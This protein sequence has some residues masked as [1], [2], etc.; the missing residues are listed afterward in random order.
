MSTV[1]IHTN[2]NKVI[3]VPVFEDSVF[4]QQENITIL[5]CKYLIQGKVSINFLPT[6]YLYEEDNTKRKLLFAYNIAIGPQRTEFFE[7]FDFVE[8]T[9]IF[10]GLSKKCKQFYL[11]E[12]NS[13]I[14]FLSFYTDTINRNKTDVYEVIIKHS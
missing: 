13:S 3:H 14:G 7:F 2:K 6:T 1:K 5:H 4:H 9:L 12:E 8:F 10:E 11:Q